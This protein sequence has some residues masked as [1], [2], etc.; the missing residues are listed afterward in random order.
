MNLIDCVV[1][2]KT[3]RETR[4]LPVFPTGRGWQPAQIS[5]WWW[6]ICW[7]ETPSPAPASGGLCT[8]PCTSPSSSFSL[9]EVTREKR[10]SF[11]SYDRCEWA[12][13]TGRGGCVPGPAYLRQH[14]YEPRLQSTSLC[15]GLNIRKWS[16]LIFLS[17]QMLHSEF[18]T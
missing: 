4:L 9:Q 13:R 1:Q 14:L 7:N 15:F 16:F 3:K 18:Q 11:N 6:C 5:S 12:G 10:W 17:S 8:R 2:A